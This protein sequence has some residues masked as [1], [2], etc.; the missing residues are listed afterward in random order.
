MKKIRNAKMKKMA[1]ELRDEIL[2]ISNDVEE[3]ITKSHVLFRTS[4]NFAGIY[5]QP[6]GFWLIVR[7]PSIELDVPELDARPQRNPNWTDIRVDERTNL[8]LL[9]K[10]ARLAY[11]RTL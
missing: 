6:R 9:V 8:N 10:A 5:S 1:G 4:L 7:V 2:K 3:R 11:Q